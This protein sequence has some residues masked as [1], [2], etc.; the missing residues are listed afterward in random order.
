MSR[1]TARASGLAA[2]PTSTL[3]SQSLCDAFCAAKRTTNFK[4][5]AVVLATDS[6][7]VVCARNIAAV[8]LPGVALPA[9]TKAGGVNA[10]ACAGATGCMPTLPCTKPPS[11]RGKTICPP[12][13][14]N[15]LPC[16]A[17][18]LFWALTT[19]LPTHCPRAYQV[20][21]QGSVTM[22]A[23]ALSPIEVFPKEQPL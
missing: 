14:P 6:P 7:V 18:A 8:D 15:V 1:C 21:E 11:R 9:A 17:Q 23:T 3:H 2:G 4:G 19:S 5:K 13:Q 12:P 16:Q 22:L 10:C 20:P